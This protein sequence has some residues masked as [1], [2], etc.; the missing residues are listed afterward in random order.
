MTN[1]AATAI[2]IASA[3][4]NRRSGDINVLAGR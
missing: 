3:S 2:L 4:Q 1:S